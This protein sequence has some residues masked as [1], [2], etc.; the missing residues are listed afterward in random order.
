MRRH[1][2]GRGSV[3]KPRGYS[4]RLDGGSPIR[5]NP[6]EDMTGFEAMVA[7]LE[8]AVRAHPTQWFNFLD[9]WAPLLGAS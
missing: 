2:A 6:G 1:G 3:V 4:H 8:G 7:A 9:V 5:V